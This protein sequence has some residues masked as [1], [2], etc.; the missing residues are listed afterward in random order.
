VG[1]LVST[2]DGKKPLADI[3]LGEVI[4]NE[5]SDAT[6]ERTVSGSLGVENGVTAERRDTRTN[7][8][9]LDELVTLGGD[10]LVL[11]NAINLVNTE[12]D[13]LGVNVG[14]ELRE[15]TAAGGREDK[16]VAGLVPLGD[17]PEQRE[18]KRANVS[19]RNEE[20]WDTFVL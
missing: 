16:L 1:G 12:V 4:I 5:L 19:T 6:T 3:T 9:D 11:I 17:E 8:G 2:A 15:V 13:G 10:A 18:R 7:E 20:N 14:L